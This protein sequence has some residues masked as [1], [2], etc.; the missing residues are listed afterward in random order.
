MTIRIL[1]V[2]DQ[3]LIRDGIKSLLQLSDKVNVVGECSD[4]TQVANALNRFNP[5]VILLDL[6]M[7]EMD[8]IATLEYLSQQDSSP[9]AL[10][11]TTFDDHELV[12]KSLKLGA[13]G[14]LLKDIS[15]ES[16]IEAIE[17]VHSGDSFIQPAITENLLKNTPETSECFSAPDILEPLSARE[18]EVLRLI[19]SGYSNKEIAGALH[20]SEGTIKN[21]VS[22]LLSKLGVRDR[23]RAVLLAIEKGILR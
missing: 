2:D 13:K 14:F 23:T 19:A 22:N 5:D 20:K 8:G 7:P 9:P 3:K 1:L 11:L 21:H 18:L 12:L 15:L 10:I 6:S 4:G 17:T 16:L